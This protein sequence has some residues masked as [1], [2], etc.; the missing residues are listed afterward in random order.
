ME[1]GTGSITVYF[2]EKQVQQRKTLCIGDVIKLTGVK[3]D[4]YL[5]TVSLKATCD[6]ELVKVDPR[7]RRE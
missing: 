1:D 3:I 5:D 6:T 4:Q 2:W 7:C